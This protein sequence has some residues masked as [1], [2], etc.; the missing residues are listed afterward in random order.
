VLKD[1]ARKLILAGLIVLLLLIGFGV[2]L[3]TRGS[4]RK[5][6]HVTQVQAQAPERPT[7]V[8]PGWT[9]RRWAP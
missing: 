5:K 1:G 6:H 8:P 2:V 7:A 3:V 9:A 4:S